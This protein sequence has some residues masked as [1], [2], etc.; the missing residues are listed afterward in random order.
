MPIKQSGMR[1]YEDPVRKTLSL[2]ESGEDLPDDDPRTRNGGLSPS[3]NQDM[4]QIRMYMQLREAGHMSD[5]AWQK[6]IQRNPHSATLFSSVQGPTNYSEYFQPGRP[7]QPGQPAQPF[8]PPDAGAFPESDQQLQQAMQSRTPGQ[9]GLLSQQ[10][11]PDVPPTPAKFDY[12]GAMATA[13]GRGDVNMANVLQRQTAPPDGESY[14]GGVQYAQDPKTG[15]FVPYVIDKTTRQARPIQTPPGTVAT[16]PMMPQAVMG[17]G[18][19]SSVVQVPSRG[20]PGDGG[21]R[22]TGLIPNHPATMD[23]AGRLAMLDQ[24]NQDVTDVKGLLFNRDGKLN[25]EIV[26]KMSVP[27]TAGIGG[28]AR[29]AYSAI[30]NA[31]GAKLRAETGATANPGEVKD[32]ANRF[33][34]SLMDDDKSAAYK[35]DR[36]QEF[37]NSS[38]KII[39]PNGLYGTGKPTSPR[40]GS[41][42]APANTPSGSERP[43][44]KYS[45]LPN[46]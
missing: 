41:Q 35:I 20:V 42:S 15:Q 19:V 3:R 9:F 26:A 6:L 36:L 14:V 38:R 5:Q 30:Y 31:V 34:P 4:Q 25:K 32:I 22:D 45:E 44:I 11:T 46:G 7:G 37:L 39:D 17:P 2:L 16:V 28:D 33:M 24:A 27:L 40:A 18:G 13:L 23:V 10:A 1:D 21:K 12:E 8:I 29:I 43:R